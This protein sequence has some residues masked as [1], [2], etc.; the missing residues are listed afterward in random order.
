MTKPS[1]TRIPA[2]EITVA[3]RKD[4]TVAVVGN[5]NSGK[6][7]LFNRLTGLK[8]RIGNYPGVTVERHVGFLRT[9]DKLV[10]LGAYWLLNNQTFPIQRQR[11]RRRNRPQNVFVTR[12]H[13]RYDAEKFPEDLQ[14]Q[15]TADRKNFQGRYV[16]R[17]PY[18]GPAICNAAERY[19]QRVAERRRQAAKNLAELTG[20]ELE[21]I[22][23][24]MKLTKAERQ[25]R[26]W[27]ERMWGK[28]EKQ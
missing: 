20:W 8:Q 15:E 2:S 1:E 25:D 14:F 21:D 4:A 10:E 18:T 22:H 7:T 11:L 13:V 28:R 17:H 19:R 12:L 9:D 3:K 24:R 27:F 26:P 23:K 6:S 5:P 16:L